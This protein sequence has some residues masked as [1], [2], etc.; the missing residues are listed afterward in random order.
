MYNMSST[1]A[2]WLRDGKKSESQK[3]RDRFLLEEDF[4]N[5]RCGGYFNWFDDR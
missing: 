2:K 1:S 4:K 3:L 5:Y